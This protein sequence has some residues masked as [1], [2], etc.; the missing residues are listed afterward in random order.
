MIMASRLIHILLVAA[1]PADSFDMAGGTL[2]HHIEQGDRVT[3]AILTTGVRSHHWELGEQRRRSGAELDVEEYVAQA[4]EEKLEEVRRACRILGFDDVRDL[5]F[6]DDDV[7]VTQDKVEAIAEVI[8]AV[9][10]DMLITHHPFE[11]GGFKMHGT[12]GQ[13]TLYAWQLAS[14]S[15]R[16][17]QERH[18]VP[19]IYFMNPTAYIGNNSLEYA[20]TARVDL[21]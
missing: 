15:G 5:G 14:G 17:R 6:E 20:G 18:P 9:K 10:P 7:L 21:Y 3:A 11:S 4:V 12:T 13:C 8:R 19:C 16:G 2:A 1:H